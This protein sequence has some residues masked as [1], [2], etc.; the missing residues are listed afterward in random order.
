MSP[1]TSTLQ[2]WVGRIHEVED[3]VTSRLLASFGATLGDYAAQTAEGAAAPGLHWC[4][5]PD[6]ADRRELGPDGHPAKG[7]FLPPVPL[8]RRMWAASDVRFL[9]PIR[10]GD[11][12]RRRSTLTGIEEK[13]GRTGPLT[14]VTVRHD[15]ANDAGPVIK[16]DQTIVYR[17]AGATAATPASPGTPPP[18]ASHE[19]WVDVDP[20]LLFRYSAL[21]FNGHRIHYDAPYA[22]MV[23]GYTGLVIHGPLQATLLLNFA[24]VVFGSS[25]RR[26]S[27]RGVH[28][29]TRPQRLLLSAT[30]PGND[31]MALEVRSAD[32]HVT[33]K[34]TAQW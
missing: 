23:E 25:P 34:A 21:T 5:T 32:G 27:F 15:I 18:A 10:S 4:L 20:V 3:V 2:E 16:E 31:G 30:S 24:T 14:F 6:I 7:G 29:A 28:P 22:T 1:D 11:R 8:P 19:R 13:Q 26:F 12:I 9:A 33:V 17:A